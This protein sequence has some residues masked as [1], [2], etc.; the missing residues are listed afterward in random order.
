MGREQRLHSI[1][2]DKERVEFLRA[3]VI[4]ECI[5]Q[6]RDCF[7]D[8][9]DDLL[10]GRFD[11]PLLRQI[12]AAG[13]MQRLIE[14][15]ERKIYCTPAVVEIE[16]AG[17][18]VIGELLEVLVQTLDDIAQKGPAATAKSRMTQYLIPEQ[19]IGPERRPS[20]DFYARLL[21]LTDFVA[22]MTDS[23]AVSL[24]KKLTGISL[25]GG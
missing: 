15:A 4:N 16:A 21:G 14:V 25:P 17:F 7:L 22:G 9:E 12:P 20:Q 13:E 1:A 8:R 23:Y 18:Q 24:Y 2:G 3:K 6:V 11:E 5:T 10:A 19:F